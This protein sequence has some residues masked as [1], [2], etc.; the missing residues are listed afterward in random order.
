MAQ[1]N[2]VKM[3]GVNKQEVF[4]E[5]LKE[6]LWW[7]ISVIIAVLVMY[8]LTSKLH[9]KPLWING[10]FIVIALTYFRYAVLLKSTYI[11]R[12]KWVR[13]LLIVVNIN[14]FIFVLRKMQGFMYIYDSFSLDAMGTPIRPLAPEEVDP[15]FRYFFDEINLTCVA[16]MALAVALSVRMVLSHWNTARVRLNAGN[17]E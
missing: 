6:L 12:S 3:S 2:A 11:L 10:A 5:I 16:C 14:F 13:F 4:L 8:P 1:Q 9:Y 17:E 15:L 7:G